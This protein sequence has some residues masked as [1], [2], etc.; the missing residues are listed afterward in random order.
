MAVESCEHIRPLLGAYSDRELEAADT[1]AV[2]AHL[3]HCAS[4]L[5]ELEEIDSLG[6]R[7]RDAF[8]LPPLE[9]FAAQVG[10]SL[11]A[12][13]RPGMAGRFREL[14]RERWMP[15]LAVAS[16]A[17]AAGAVVLTLLRVP[18][19]PSPKPAMVA[20]APLSEP[21]PGVTPFGPASGSSETFI[22]RLQTTDPSVAVWSEPGSKTTVIWLPDDNGAS[23]NN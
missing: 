11:P 1:A 16:M 23:G 22:S 5:R 2:Q 18:T 3:S 4:C 14:L 12:A 7:L 6:D 10:L 21:S 8:P 19:Q 13:S 9:G 20:Q 17:L 15:S